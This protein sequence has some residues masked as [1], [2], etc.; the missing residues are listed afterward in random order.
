MKYIKTY[1]NLDYRDIDY[2][3]IYILKFPNLISIIGKLKMKVDMN[4][5][6]SWDIEG[7]IVQT[8]IES[9]PLYS[10]TSF[11]ISL[12]DW[13]FIYKSTPEEIEQYEIL[14]NTRKYN[15]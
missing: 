9:R 12:W 7:Y 10:F 1:E 14:N 15:L 8:N 5:D 6:R 11:D 4:G 2:D 13:K 3:K